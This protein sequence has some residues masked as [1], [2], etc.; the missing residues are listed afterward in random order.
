M[1]IRERGGGRGKGSKKIYF[2]SLMNTSRGTADTGKP[3]AEFHSGQ[4][5]GSLRPLEGRAR[6]KSK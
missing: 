6:D 5:S 3:R 1:P 2:S 4:L